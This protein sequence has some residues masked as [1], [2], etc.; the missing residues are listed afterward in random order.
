MNHLQKKINTE[1]IS[2]AIEHFE[3]DIEFEFIPVI[4]EKS[5]YVEHIQWICSLFFLL[6]FEGTIDYFFQDSYASK[7]PYYVAAPIL[8]ILLGTLLDKSDWI[9]RFFI[10]KK[11][12]NRQVYEKAERIF[13]KKKLH[14][15]KTHNALLLYISVMERKIVLLPDPRSNIE[16]IKQINEKLLAL[17]QKAFK[18]N[19]YQQGLLEAIEQLRSELIHK[20]KKTSDTPNQFSN[21]LIWWND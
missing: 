3:R 9:D 18:K 4:A 6:L 10:S 16:N 15:S 17:L 13:Y 20:H 12:R 5:S 8:G 11:E 21:K 7:I 14:E 2:K 1:E 19:E